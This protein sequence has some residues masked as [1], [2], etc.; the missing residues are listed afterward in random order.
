MTLEIDSLKES[1]VFLNTVIDN[2]SSALF[3]ADSNAK[4]SA[5]NVTFEKLFGVNGPDI[6]GVLCGNVIG[7]SFL[8]DPAS[9]CGS[10]EY[11]NECALRKSL[12]TALIDKTP[13]YDKLLDREF[14]INDKKVFKHFKFSV[15]PVEYN[16]EAFAVVVVDDI[17]E[18]QIIRNDLNVKNNELM[19]L[20]EQKNR[21]LGMTAHD[22]RNPIGSVK[23]IIDFMRENY[24]EMNE[25]KIMEFLVISGES[26]DNALGIINDLLDITAIESGKIELKKNKIALRVIAEKVVSRNAIFAQKKNINIV[27]NTSDPEIAVNADPLRIDQLI[28]NLVTNAVKYSPIGGEIAISIKPAD[29]QMIF[30]IKDAGVG[31]PEDDKEKIFRPFGKAKVKTTGGETST[32]LGLAISKKIADSHGGNIWFESAAGKGSEFCFSLPLDLS[33]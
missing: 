29:G 5:F 22:L 8:D 2:I 27:L 4:I 14:W 30:S 16:G 28:G 32:G 33:S 13:V 19:S 26:L 17:T 10:T 3:V 21:F 6:M 1:S 24:N 7:C 9:E 15:R 12:M 23:T 31:I 11:C 20:V 18:M 25:S